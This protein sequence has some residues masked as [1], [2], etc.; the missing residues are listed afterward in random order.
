MLKYSIMM[1]QKQV[2]STTAAIAKSEQSVARDYGDATNG[3]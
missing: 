1:C 3:Q 2:S